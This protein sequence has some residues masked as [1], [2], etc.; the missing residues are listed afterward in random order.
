MLDWTSFVTGN[1]LTKGNKSKI[2]EDSVWADNRLFTRA[3]TNYLC[4]EG[5]FQLSY[6][7]QAACNETS[8]AACR[9]L[10]SGR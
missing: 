6:G 3:G 1:P 4:D 7:L 10:R 8:T 5:P 2:V 9:R